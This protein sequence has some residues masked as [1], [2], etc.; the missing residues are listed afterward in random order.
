LPD[1]CVVSLIHL[2]FDPACSPMPFQPTVHYAMGGIPTN[3]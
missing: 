3:V 1:L 2:G